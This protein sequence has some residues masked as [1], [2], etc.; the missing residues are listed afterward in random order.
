MVGETF[1]NRIYEYKYERSG[2][3]SMFIGQDGGR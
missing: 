1:R 2:K 3:N